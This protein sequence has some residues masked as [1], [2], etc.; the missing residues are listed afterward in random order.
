M[1]LA[2]T[3]E[4]KA[5]FPGTAQVILSQRH[6][7]S[8]AQKA[9]SR[10]TAQMLPQEVATPASV[11]DLVASATAVVSLGTSLG[12]ALSRLVE[13]LVASAAATEVEV[14]KRLVTLA[15][16]SVICPG[17]VCK[18]ASA[19]TA[20]KLVTLAETVLSLK[21]ARA[22]HVALKGNVEAQWANLNQDDKSLV[23]EQLEELQKKDWKQLSIDE[24]K[25]AYYVAFGPH[26]PRTPINPPGTILKIF[27]G[28]MGLVG[29]AGALF[30]ALRQIAPPPPKTLTKEWEEASNE[31]AIE[32][33]M[34]PITGIT[35]EGYSGKG[36]VQHK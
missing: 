28:T 3:A 21:S 10:G 18:E 13:A 2:T 36:F 6:A 25:A 4:E 34:N 27:L 11:E 15:E 12:H 26:G 7:T 31:R 1:F 9:I 23:I 33:K 19:T 14:T 5:T 17:I 29:A 22:T 20:H 8:V 32:Q 24:K 16:A 30:L 35:S